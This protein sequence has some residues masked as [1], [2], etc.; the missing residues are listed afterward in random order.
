MR[1]NQLENK[2]R[3]AVANAYQDSRL[4]EDASTYAVCFWA[5]AKTLPHAVP[6]DV[7]KAEHGWSRARTALVEVELL[8]A[9]FLVLDEGQ[10]AFR[11][12]IDGIPVWGELS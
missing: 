11:P 6:T 7:M 12:A 9:G 3:H 1:Y 2:H 5:T 10:W 8:R 4:S